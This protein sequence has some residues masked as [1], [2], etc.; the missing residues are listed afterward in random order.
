MALKLKHT[1]QAEIPAELQR[2][3]VERD[4]HWH[5]DVEGAVEKARL[6]EFRA[7]NVDLLKRVQD[8]EQRFAGI[9]P[10]EVRALAEEKR[11]LEEQ[12]RLKAGE[13]EQVIAARVQAVRGELETKL[14]ATVQERD[15]ATARLAEVLVDQAVLSEAGKRALRPAAA[16][17]ILARARG[18][19]RLVDGSVRVLEGQ[20]V[21]LG[22]DGVT[23]MTVAEYV[24][25]LTAAAPH[26]FEGNA[27]SGAA[28]H[29]S[30]GAGGVGQSARNP[31]RRETWNL[32]EQM[33][34]QKTDPQLAARLK[35][36]A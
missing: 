34:L 23:P 1:S 16:A 7:T 29:G 19:V 3:Y 18:V 27:G 4:G 6:D 31:Y 28:G 11:R 26:L 20:T 14:H 30:G 32:T 25:G 8:F 13:V 22:K 2:L 33:R 17:D 10:D 5:L 9:N 15:S 24:D 36:A 12:Q 35:A 21:R